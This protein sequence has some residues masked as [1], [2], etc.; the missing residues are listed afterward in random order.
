[1]RRLSPGELPRELPNSMDCNGRVATPQ[2]AGSLQ[3]S[4]EDPRGDLHRGGGWHTQ[5]VAKYDMPATNATHASTH[6]QS[7]DTPARHGCELLER[8]IGTCQRIQAR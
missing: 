4:P 3:H 2:S 6:L 1:M 5:K 8:Q 7:K